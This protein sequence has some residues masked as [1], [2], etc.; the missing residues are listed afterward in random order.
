MALFLTS[1]PFLSNAEIT[2]KMVAPEPPGEAIEKPFAP[3]PPREMVVPEF[4]ENLSRDELKSQRFVLTGLLVEGSTVYAGLDFA[5]FYKP[6]LNKHISLAE[7]VRIARAITQKYQRNGFVL[8]KALV[9][10]QVIRR[11]VVRIQVL[12]GYVDEVVVEGPMRDSSNMLQR[13]SEKIKHSQPLQKEILERYL[14]LIKDFSGLTVE[15]VI[16]PSSNNKAASKLTL[17]VQHKFLEGAVGVDNRGSRLQGPFRVSAGGKINSLFNRF[18]QT[19]IDFTMA[20]QPDEL[21]F[22]NGYHRQPV[23]TEGAQLKVSGLFSRSEPGNKLDR[24][25]VDGDT[26]KISAEIEHPFIR[27][28]MHNFSGHFSF[29]ARDSHVDA[30]DKVI[31][32]DRV[33]YLGFGLD[34]DFRDKTRAIN[35]LGVEL[36]QGIDVFD[37]TESGTSNLS[38]KSGEHDFTKLSGDLMRYQPLFP[39]W[40]FLAEASWQYS[41]SNL[42]AAEEFGV[43]GPRYARAYDSSEI[44]GDHGIAFKIELQYQKDLNHR[45]LKSIQPY[46][47]FDHGTIWRKTR[48]SGIGKEASLQSTGFGARFNLVDRISGYAEFAQPLSD[49][50]LS[51]GDR[52]PRFFFSVVGRF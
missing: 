47:F 27:S 7:I 25:L 10:P 35:R 50:V 52:D 13:F 38:R 20:T 16:T 39:H 12:E 32:R 18:D 19:G 37:A 44:T 23:G 9:P 26:H 45:Y 15:P 34:Y 1:I 36:N 33:R 49:D 42:L 41:F 31:A 4:V 51:E 6:Y 22:F 3:R 5:P 28:M 21:V 43:G 24:F 40:Y 8:S 14:L 30:L 48:L 46:A 2:P 29:S 17:K 11:G